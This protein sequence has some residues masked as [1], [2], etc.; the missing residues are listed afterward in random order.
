MRDLLVRELSHRLKNVLAVVQS[1]AFLSLRNSPSLEAFQHSFDE[2]LRSLARIYDHL[3]R[4]EWGQVDL[5]TLAMLSLEPYREAVETEGDPVMLTA[6]EA[7]TLGMVLHELATNAIKH[8]ALSLP[9]GRVSFTWHD[10]DLG[11]GPLL[12]LRWQ[13]SNGPKVVPPSKTGMGTRMIDVS[14]R[15]SFGGEVR[16]DYAE[17]GVCWEIFI[18]K[19]ELGVQSFTAPP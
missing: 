4:V 15:H 5:R 8:G 9:G 17:T 10:Q 6:T 7:A 19:R 13:E 3:A 11:L 1:I 14:V 2:R 18:P 16:V 12:I